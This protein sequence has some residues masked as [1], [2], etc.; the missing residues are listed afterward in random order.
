MTELTEFIVKLVTQYKKAM[1]LDDPEKLKQYIRLMKVS[2]FDIID[3]DGPEELKCL[4]RL[5][6]DRLDEI[7]NTPTVQQ[8]APAP[9]EQP[10]QAPAAEKPS[11]VPYVPNEV[12]H[13][14]P[15][16]SGDLIRIMFHG[17]LIWFY[18]DSVTMKMTGV[19]AGTQKLKGWR[20]QGYN[21]MACERYKKIRTIYADAGTVIVAR[22]KTKED[23]GID[24]YLV[25]EDFTKVV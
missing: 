18:V 16:R 13:S 10:V 7:I 14:H 4:I 22:G 15:I 11:F 24:K 12:Q 8:P 6:E 20:L 9:E 5:T 21:C 2:M 23:F 17:K 19:N 25:T 1:S 3:N